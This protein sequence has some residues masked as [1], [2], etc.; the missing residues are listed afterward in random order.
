MQLSRKLHV[1]VSEAYKG[2]HAPVCGAGEIDGPEFDIIF[3]VGA[4]GPDLI[5]AAGRQTAQL[6]GC[7]IHHGHVHGE[8]A[9]VEVG[10]VQRHLKRGTDR[11]YVYTY[12]AK[13]SVRTVARKIKTICRTDVNQPLPVLLRQLNSM[14]R[15]WC[16]YFRPGVSSA[17]FQF[18]RQL[19][20]GQA[21]R[22]IRRKHRRITS[23]DLRRR[24]CNGGWWPTTEDIT[25][26]DPAKVR[27]T[28]YRY[29][30]AVIPSPWPT[31]G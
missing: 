19:V 13:K 11:H 2:W 27:T 9:H 16:A 3:A 17:T 5:S 6:G 24:Y 1:L 28:R 20:W 15:G 14:L 31:K 4:K 22:W 30:G 8:V 25:L 10:V 7:V 12:P 18:L 21:I 23:K 29:R 26:F